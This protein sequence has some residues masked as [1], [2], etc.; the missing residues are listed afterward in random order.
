MKQNLIPRLVPALL[1]VSALSGCTQTAAPGPSG[2]DSFRFGDLLKSDIDQVSDLHRRQARALLKQLMMKLY[3]RNPRQWRAHGKPSARFMLERV[4]RPRRVPDFTELNGRRGV[5]CIRLA[6][7]ADYAGDR[8]LAFSA[9]LTAMLQKAYLDK[10]EFYLTDQLDAQKLYNSAR[11]IEIAAWLLR[12]SRDPG[13]RLYLLSHS[14]AAGGDVNL[15]FERLFGK[16][17][18]TQDNLAAIVAGRSRRT[19][20]KVVQNMMGAV[21]LP[22]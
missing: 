17:I 22:I 9:G 7:K 5:A 4:F 2:S 19:I 10:H 15:S 11:N 21:F 18:A 6:F 8:V 14:P 16:L 13:G 20:K 1:I 3:K 12:T